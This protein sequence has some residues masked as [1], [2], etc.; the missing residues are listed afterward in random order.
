MKARPIPPSKR[1]RASIILEVAM[2]YGV[3][4]IMAIYLLK[5]AVS[6]TSGQRWTVI[7]SM[8]DAFMTQESAIGTRT[9]LE[10]LTAAA[11]QFPTFPA[12]AET[13]VTIGRLPGGTPVTGTLRRT[14][15]PDANN[16][17]EAG[18]SGTAATNPAGMEAWKLQSFLIYTMGSRTYVKS[19]TTVRVR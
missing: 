13:T 1:S 5:S 12:T 14:K 7:Q 2:A 10:D 19:R 16:L 15:R 8:T 18:G 11:S 3:L 9:P 6:I 4:M 17:P